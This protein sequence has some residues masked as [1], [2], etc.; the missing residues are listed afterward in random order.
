MSFVPSTQ[1]DIRL[2]LWSVG[3][4]AWPEE[5]HH[6]KLIHNLSSLK[7]MK[8]A[9]V[10]FLEGTH[11]CSPKRP[12]SFPLSLFPAPFPA[13]FPAEAA[14]HLSSCERRHCHHLPDSSTAA[15]LWRHQDPP[16]ESRSLLCKFS[17]WLYTRNSLAPGNLP[18]IERNVNFKSNGMA[19]A[20]YKLLH[21]SM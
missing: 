13:P 20:S 8:S 16:T 19:A 17:R 12:F 3:W 10:V 18:S 15:A 1:K 11:R 14:D 5:I 4:R 21:L 7:E 9:G 6:R 2:E